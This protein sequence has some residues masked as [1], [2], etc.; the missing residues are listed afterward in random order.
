MMPVGK[1]YPYNAEGE[2]LPSPS[3]RSVLFRSV[4]VEG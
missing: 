3:R 1:P 2:G 4:R